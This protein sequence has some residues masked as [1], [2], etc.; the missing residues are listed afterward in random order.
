MTYS[1]RLI[2]DTMFQ[3][4]L[5]L[6]LPL[7][8]FVSIFLGQSFNGTIQYD[9]EL[10]GPIAEQILLNEPNNEIE[11][12]VYEGDYIV[13]LKGGRY[14]KTFLYINKKDREFSVDAAKQ[15][16]YKYNPHEDINRETQKSQPVAVPTDKTGEVN[17]EMCQ[18]YGMKKDGA[19]MLFYVS[20]KYAVD[21][22]LFADKVQAKPNFLVKGLGGKIPL[23][24]VKKQNG[25][26]VTTTCTNIRER[27][28]DKSQFMIPPGFK[29][30]NRDYRP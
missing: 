5:F 11:M 20:E 9:V 3:K 21:T 13:N 18:V 14:P 15:T 12:H 24:T 23:K 17:G 25:L 6:T 27:E 1:I 28:F 4:R 8:F 16:V 26:I 29:I 19:V 22:T 10:K 30:K 7:L 2:F